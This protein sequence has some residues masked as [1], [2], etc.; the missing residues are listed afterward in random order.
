[1]KYSYIIIDND[2]KAVDELH[3]VLS[4]FPDFYCR[5]IAYNE[6]DAIDLVLEQIPHIIF[7]D[8]DMPGQIN[9]VSKFSILNE[10]RHYLSELPTVIVV[11]CTE[12]YAL[13]AIKHGV[14]DYVVKPSNKRELRK[15]LFRYT[16]KH[17]ES[18]DTLCLQSYG[19][20]KFLEIDDIQYLKADNNNT[21]FFLNDGRK[22]SA[23]KTLKHF[24]QSL[25]SYFVRVHNS[26]IINTNYVSRIHFGKSKCSIK[27]TEQ[28][29]PFSRTYK[30]NVETMKNLMKNKNVLEF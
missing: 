13:P 27:Y 10:L 26:Y 1:M 11:T 29:I 4:D 2:K 14:L 19:D 3:K 9:N 20:Y 24:E 23:F 30:H 15:A 7:M 22:V 25:P 6:E 16:K 5:G 12:K 17:E 18:K 28:L 21:D 8:P